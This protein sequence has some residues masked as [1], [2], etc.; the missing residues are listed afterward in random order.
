MSVISATA[1]PSMVQMILLIRRVG[2]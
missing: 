1:A 2:T